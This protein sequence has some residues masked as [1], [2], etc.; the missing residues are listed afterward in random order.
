MYGIAPAPQINPYLINI[1]K[2]IISLKI[3]LFF[4]MEN[5]NT[6]YG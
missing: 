4:E 3:S 5:F 2:K 6:S 1:F